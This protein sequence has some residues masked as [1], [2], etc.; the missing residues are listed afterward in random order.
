MGRTY[1]VRFK[2]L[3]ENIVVRSL[4]VTAWKDGPDEEDEASFPRGN[5]DVFEE[6]LTEDDLC[7]VDEL[8]RAFF[9]S[10]AASCG[11]AEAEETTAGVAC[12]A[13]FLA[14]IAD[15]ATEGI[16]SL[17]WFLGDGISTAGLLAISEKRYIAVPDQLI[18]CS[19][20][21]Q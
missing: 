1:S 3:V 10:E 4:T 17:T 18:S 19:H 7:E 20:L 12:T 14:T 6:E 21:W 15:G 8:F 5:V 11:S 16:A 9:S 2:A 13:F